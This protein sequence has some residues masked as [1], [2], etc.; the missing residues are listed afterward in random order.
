M[1]I[2]AS[3]DETIDEAARRRFEQA[4]RAG[5]EPE[6][7]V[8]LPP[9]DSARYLPTLEELVHIDLEFRWAKTKGTPSV[10]ERH[11]LESYIGRFPVL[12]GPGVLSRLVAQE[13]HVRTRA[14]EPPA[15]DDYARRF[16][17]MVSLT[18]DV[19]SPPPTNA[20]PNTNEQTL[21]GTARI[22]G[23]EI[24][25]V[26]GRG[27][28]G[29]VYQARDIRLNR[30]V[31]IKMLLSGL[32]AG[33]EE[34]ERFERE[35]AAVA[36]LQHANIVQVYELGEADGRL[37]IVFE[38]VSGGNLSQKLAATPLAA[39]EAAEL[40]V[41]LAD[42]IEHAHS[43]QIIHR[44]LKPTNVMLT[45][46]GIPKI[47]DFGLAKQ[48]AAEEGATRTGDVLGTPSYMAPEQASGRIRDIGPPTD[49]YA[50]GAIL[51]ECLTGRPPFRADSAWETVSQV[52]SLEPVAPCQLQPRLPSDLETICLK[53]LEKDPAK[54]YA[55]ARELDEELRRFLRHEPIIARPAGWMEKFWR[56]CVRNP[57]LAAA[58]G[59]IAVFLMLTAA[60]GVAFGVYQQQVADDLSEANEETK[61]EQGKTA[62]ALAHSN[63]AAAELLL[64]E[65]L[66]YCARG[67]V[68]LGLLRMAQAF[69]RSGPKGDDL[70]RL[71]RANLAVW[72]Q[73]L[74]RL[75]DFTR[76]PSPVIASAISRDGQKLAVAYE[77][78][79][80]SA[81]LVIWDGAK[82]Q[83]IGQPAQLSA[84]LPQL[85]I[86]GSGETL[87]VVE[88]SGGVRSFALANGQERGD[89]FSLGAAVNRALVS[90]DGKHLVAMHQPIR[91]SD[92]QVTR[93]EVWSLRERKLLAATEIPG[94][95]RAYFHPDG[96][97]FVSSMQGN[98]ELF[99]NE[100]S[101]LFH[102]K[103]P[104]WKEADPPRPYRGSIYDW[105]VSP[106]GTRYALVFG[107][108]TT[109]LFDTKT[110]QQLGLAQVPLPNN[111][112]LVLPPGL[113]GLAPLP[114]PPPIPIP[115]ANA[116]EPV[117]LPTSLRFALPQAKFSPD[118]RWLAAAE[119]KRVVVLR[120]RDGASQS[121][122][123]AHDDS[124]DSLAFSR[125][126]QWL[127][128]GSL[129]GR[130]QIWDTATATAKGRSLR[131]VGKAIPQK[132][133]VFA[134]SDKK[135]PPE[136]Q[137]PWL[138]GELAFIGDR[139]RLLAWGDGEVVETW[140]VADSIASAGVELPHAGIVNHSYFHPRL[141][142]L[143]TISILPPAATPAVPATPN[144]PVLP[145]GPVPPTSKEGPRDAPLNTIEDDVDPP[146]PAAKSPNPLFPPSP[147]IPP[148]AGPTRCG[149]YA[150]DLA[151]RPIGGPQIVEGVVSCAAM[152]SEGELAIG[153]DGGQI[154]RFDSAMKP[155]DTL[156]LEQPVVSIGW[157]RD[158]K[159]LFT[160][161][162]GGYFRR[163]SLAGK[164]IEP[165]LA[166]QRDGYQF[167]IG[168]FEVDDS[169]Q[170]LVVSAALRGHVEAW[171]IQGEQLLRETL[172][173]GEQTLAIAL[174]RDARR[175]FV[176]HFQWDRGEGKE[177]G[178][179]VP[180]LFPITSL[181]FSPD[182]KIIAVGSGIEGTAPH[183]E[184]R[185]FRTSDSQPLGPP[186]PHPSPVKKLEFDSKGKILLSHSGMIGSQSSTVRL[187]DAATGKPLGP[188]FRETGETL[189]CALHPSGS[190]VV[191][192][193]EPHATMEL[194]IPASGIQG[195]AEAIA[196]RRLAGLGMN[197]EAQWQ[198]TAHLWRLPAPVELPAESI[199]PWVAS[200]TRRRL[201][202][203]GV[204]QLLSDDEWKAARAAVKGR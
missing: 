73:Q 136:R 61:K 99:G 113:G 174:R 181:A 186:L 6:L 192:G 157:S 185:V 187:C 93:L 69:D 131:A 121:N 36:R 29:V 53:C 87:W 183:G 67:D 153:G 200:L 45:H 135:K 123:E 18:M 166:F 8:Y 94:F 169:G 130:I 102:Y 194:Q 176:D 32:H 27:G 92:E 98:P 7:S 195:L 31:A 71:I 68:D 137:V 124:I 42:A 51:Y 100:I 91:P 84:G 154:W 38:F 39:N 177:I 70:R 141:P 12:R 111:G 23:Y 117:R 13:R 163:W 81:R 2:D 43:H 125:D 202:P 24:L 129:D 156:H 151:G 48:L 35:A 14:G 95:A 15:A 171:Q 197:P 10:A 60:S 63:L 1:S 108:G 150:W 127:A 5:S 9:L 115:V 47:G 20:T 118:G 17:G 162:I 190:F 104:D 66:R 138:P 110:G 106:D 160:A 83:A 55:T 4:W 41:T 144:P 59:I 80:R 132:A 158:G 193:G 120:A 105:V 198:G 65:A 79:D 109:I 103:L 114:P 58:G 86:D 49:V 167:G 21:I 107:G 143:V 16:P 116:G 189:C 179:P 134:K 11:L 165:D 56:W 78:A 96:S 173:Q 196:T 145:M 128:T 149:I 26:L 64:D 119:G 52:L 159:V 184:A 90:P 50:L 25:E 34:K 201:D 203:H 82:G 46:D 152:S 44:D 22:P 37:F 148:A 155:R 62:E 188:E 77:E 182:G 112:A 40:I 85:A 170:S 142:Q 180:H 122:W 172:L 147:P 199:T 54:R 3:L 74:A 19:E 164:A 146:L 97:L 28:I 76:L 191:T 75:D 101:Q 126:G 139:P 175:I 33:S 72:G 133:A 89:S 204:P 140:D 178:Q 168:R 57:A 161:G 30:L 88:G